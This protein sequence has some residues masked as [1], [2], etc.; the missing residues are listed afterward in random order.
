[1]S[2]LTEASQPGTATLAN[3]K[4]KIGE[5][6]PAYLLNTK[7]FPAIERKNCRAH[8][9]YAYG[10][11]LNQQ[12]C[13]PAKNR[14]Q[15]CNRSD[16][17]PTL[18]NP[19][20]LH[21]TVT[22]YDRQTSPPSSIHQPTNTTSQRC[23]TPFAKA[24]SPVDLHSLWQSFLQSNI[25]GKATEI[26][27]HPRSVETQKYQP[28]LRRWFEFCGKQDASYNPS[29]RFSLSYYEQGLTYTQHSQKCYMY[30]SS[31]SHK[32]PVGSHL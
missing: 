9:Q 16:P 3:L 22:P 5:P 26:I 32:T 30:I 2:Q 4:G 24:T 31:Q 11:P 20:L 7:K 27:L 13:M 18:A 6:D 1:M 17:G 28:Y 10:W 29:A 15:R 21:N 23:S 14:I 12:G 19:T 25:S 8:W